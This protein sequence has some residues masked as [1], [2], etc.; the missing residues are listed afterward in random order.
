MYEGVIGAGEEA[1][2]GFARESYQVAY[3]YA[4]VNRCVMFAALVREAFYLDWVAVNAEICKS[5]K[6]FE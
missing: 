2:C 4:Y 1:Y 6:S 3:I 5:T